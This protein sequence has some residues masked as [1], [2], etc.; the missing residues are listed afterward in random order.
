M[1]YLNKLSIKKRMLLLIIVPSV[2]LVIFITSAFIRT[3]SYNRNMSDM[4]VSL[5]FVSH[6]VPLLSDLVEE[7]NKTYAYIKKEG[8]AVKEKSDMLSSRSTTDR[9]IEHLNSFLSENKLTMIE[10]FQSEANYNDFL[11]RLKTLDYIRKVADSKQESSDY[12]KAEFYNQTIWAGVDISRLAD[13]LSDTVSYATV[14]ASHDSDVVNFANSYY[15]LLKAKLA[16]LNLHNAI[17]E[18]VNI[19]CAPYPF[20]QVMHYRALEDSYRN[21]F[22]RYAPSEVKSIFNADFV[23]S[24]LLDQLIS[25]YWKAFDCYKLFG[26]KLDLGTNWIS[27]KDKSKN[28][29]DDTVIQVMQKLLEM[30]ENKVSSAK[31]QMWSL[32]IFSII[33]L[34]IIESFGIML[35]KS[36]NSGLFRAINIMNRISDHKDMTLRLDDKGNNEISKMAFSFNR[37][38]HSFQEAIISV[39]DAVRNARKSVDEGETK[40]RYTTQSCVEQQ[41]ST[42]SISSAMHEMSTNIME[43]SKVAQQA[44]EGV[45]IAHDF[46]IGSEEKWNFCRESLDNLTVKLKYASESVLELNRE[47]ERICGILD[48][49]QGIAEQTNLLAL[50]AAIEAAR[51]GESGKGFA[52]VAD[53]VRS[54][55]LRSKDSTQ[56]IRNQI[57]KLVV[58]ANRANDCML[59]L[60]KDGKNSVDMVI[61][62]SES[63]TKIRGELDKITELTTVLAAAADEQANVSNHITERIVS[64]KEASSSI[65]R[66]AQDTEFSLKQLSSDFI[67]LEALV[68]KFRIK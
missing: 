2:A 31:T 25:V 58:V 63:F 29:Y 23:S 21:A 67:S 60:Q 12:Y 8:E 53:E 17:D 50:N 35:L 3:V 37:L 16:S 68:G 45:N 64:I 42:D 14:F 20:G 30:G 15:W 38:V 52:V 7:Q 26:Q 24:G 39:N 6:I 54:L 43:V 5:H 41:S 49:I 4:V 22:L 13:F 18:N 40:M 66:S 61:T 59:E 9:D 19:S 47:T 32:I 46:S 10:I 28:A 36:I 27:L 34:I 33:L 11:H 44:A 1:D 56:Q 55:A 57:D 48:I 51:A 65:D 62:S